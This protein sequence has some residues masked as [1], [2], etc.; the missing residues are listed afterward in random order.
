MCLP[1]FVPDLRCTDPWRSSGLFHVLRM[2]TWWIEGKE[3][4]N[5]RP[6]RVQTCVHICQQEEIS[7]SVWGWVQRKT[8]YKRH[9]W[10]DGTVPCQLQE[11]QGLLRGRTCLLCKHEHVYKCICFHIN[12]GAVVPSC[13]VVELVA[14]CW[15]TDCR[16]SNPNAISLF[17]LC[18][19]GRQMAEVH[20]E[21]SHL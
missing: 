3:W 20:F 14:A 4:R 9:M 1:F 19:L 13:L 7:V 11:I 10:M 18:S 17:Y 15:A 2:G 6:L 8:G 21:E 5:S 12:R 16:F